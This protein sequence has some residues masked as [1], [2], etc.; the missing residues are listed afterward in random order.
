[1]LSGDV[2]AASGRAVLFAL[3]GR[4]IAAVDAVG[5]DRLVRIEAGLT[6]GEAGATT[7]GID[8]A[9]AELVFAESVPAVGLA[10]RVVRFRLQDAGGVDA[11]ARDGRREIDAADDDET[12]DDPSHQMT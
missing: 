7:R 9:A 2:A 12:H 5:Q 3:L 11:R 8:V 6:A 1:V 10:L 4:R